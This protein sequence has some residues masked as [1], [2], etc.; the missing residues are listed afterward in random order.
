MPGTECRRLRGQRVL[1]GRFA[2]VLTLGF[3][4]SAPAFANTPPYSGNDSGASSDAKVQFLIDK[5]RKAFSDGELLLALIQARSAVHIGPQDGQARAQLG[6]CLMQAGD[7][8]NAED[9]LRRALYF[10]A[11]DALVLP[12][13]FGAMLARGEYEQLLD[14]YPDPGTPP[15]GPNAA[16]ILR[17]R[18]VAQQSIGEPE[19]ATLSMTRSLAL[20]RDIK[21]LV[22]QADIA[23]QQGDFKFA[24]KMSDEAL[25]QDPKDPESLD[26]RVRVALAMHLGNLALTT[27]DQLVALH[28]KSLNSRLTRIAVY[29]AM[30]M[31]DKAHGEI[32]YVSKQFSNLA[33]VA[34]YRALVQARAGDMNG[35]WK[36]G[37]TLPHELNDTDPNIALNVAEMAAHSGHLDPAAAIL[38]AA[39]A[40][41]PHDLEARLD[42][43]AICLKQNNPSDALNVLLPLEDS[44]DPVVAMFFVRTYTA[45]HRPDDAKKYTEIVNANGG[46]AVA[47]TMSLKKTAELLGEWLKTNPN[48]LNARRRYAEL[49]LDLGYNVT[50]RIQYEMIIKAAPN[51]VTALNNLG[52]LLQKTDP[53]RALSLVSTAAKL[54]PDTANVFDTE[55]WIAFEQH[56]RQTALSALEHA[57][58]LDSKDATISCHLA[59]VLDALGRRGEA[60]ALLKTALAG[61]NVN[62]LGRDD[63]ARLLAS[64]H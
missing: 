13:L 58:E 26:L 14:E 21:G 5:S 38:H 18:A 36:I 19:D 41:W 47:V 62:F 34:Y 39:I 6:I 64:M 63:A 50:A 40:K 20:L 12:H 1:A 59:Q 8:V 33:I 31:D 17:A 10:G 43:A 16:I 37:M 46:A 35:A 55:G 61:T 9:Q 25:A 15:V 60:K 45:L 7:A 29:L 44:K 11:S 54:S 3:C 42:L 2:A 53:H 30:D 24:K 22:I 51:D 52:W 56:D 32:E 28:P 4:L 57:H 27:A 23:L 49:L 48:D